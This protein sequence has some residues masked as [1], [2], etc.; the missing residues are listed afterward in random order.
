MALSVA[1]IQVSINVSGQE[2]A[3]Q[4]CWLVTVFPF[5]PSA[6]EG[7]RNE[8]S[9]EFPSHCLERW[10][11]TWERAIGAPR[12]ILAMSVWGVSAEEGV[13]FVAGGADRLCCSAS[14]SAQDGPAPRNYLAPNVSII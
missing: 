4:G 8:R 10:F 2:L 7:E 14:H 12:G 11:S 5:A 6:F 9:G 3:S 1:P 13:A